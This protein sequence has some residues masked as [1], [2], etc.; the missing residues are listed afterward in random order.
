MLVQSVALGVEEIESL[1]RIFLVF[2]N[3]RQAAPLPLVRRLSKMYRESLPFKMTKVTRDWEFKRPR[4][5]L[6]V[7]TAFMKRRIILLNSVLTEMNS[8]P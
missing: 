7:S 2:L 1:I 3:S 8:R 5:Y 4:A 6:G